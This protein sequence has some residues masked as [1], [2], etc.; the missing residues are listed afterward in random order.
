MSGREGRQP[1]WPPCFDWKNSAA[2]C[3][4]TLVAGAAGAAGAAG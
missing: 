1:C 4:S 2:L 3:P